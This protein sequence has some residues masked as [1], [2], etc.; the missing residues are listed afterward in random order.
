MGEKL[1]WSEIK[2]QYPDE[3][4]ELIEC[5]W[6]DFEVDPR[7]GIVRDH[8]KKRKELHERIMKKPVDDSAIVYTGKMKIPEGSIFSANLHQYGRK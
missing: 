5:D 3:W 7:S 6:D 2:S 1:T 4:V 8:A